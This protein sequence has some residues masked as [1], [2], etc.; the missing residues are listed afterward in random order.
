MKR[1]ER[2]YDRGRRGTKSASLRY[3]VYQWRPR[4][5]GHVVIY[6]VVNG[7]VEIVGIYHT[8]ENWHSQYFS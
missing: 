1:L 2:D 8:A 5:H 6:E 7:V 3:I 4:R